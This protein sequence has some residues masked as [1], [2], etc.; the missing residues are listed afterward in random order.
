M[1]TGIHGIGGAAVDGSARRPRS[2]WRAAG[3]GA[4]R[5]A[6][7]LMELLIVIGI[8]VVLVGILLPSLSAARKRGYRTQ[9]Q[10]L[11]S[12]L[13]TDIDA[14]YTRFHAYPGPLSASVSTALNDK[15]SG[16]QNMLLGL[17]YPIVS[18]SSYTLPPPA[19]PTTIVCP[20]L[21]KGLGSA[22]PTYKWA[23]CFAP[24]G[25]V[26]LAS[27]K[28]DGSFEHL[29]PYLAPT[30][31]QLF[32]FST[33]NTFAGMS[34]AGHNVFKFPVV[35]DTFPDGL[36]ILYYRRTVGVEE[37][38]KPGQPNSLI[39]AGYYFD[40]NKEYTNPDTTNPSD[41]QLYSASG[42]P[43]PQNAIVPSVGKVT[44]D[45][46]VL[47]RL[48][49]ADGTKTGKV[50]GGYVLISAGLDRYYGGVYNSVLDTLRRN[51]D[52]VIVGGD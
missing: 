45:E 52:I 24:T 38:A 32:D 11:M 18:N 36:P 14:Y 26:D 4:V 9:T 35:I 30:A 33:N 10:A 27:Q 43:F 8:I 21:P 13:A 6:F 51:D 39:P 5:R 19:P 25:P 7:T 22:E 37:P 20:P 31:K 49:S 3:R 50:H 40:E 41:P 2:Q 46:N 12:N 44:F 29:P 15:I 23:D 17:S 47:N 48:V 1:F 28:P 16:S 42:V 34:F